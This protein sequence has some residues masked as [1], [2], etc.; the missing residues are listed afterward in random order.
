MSFSLKVS[1]ALFTNYVDKAVPYASDAAG[2]WLMGS[3][4]DSRK[5]LITGAVSSVIG[6][7]VYGKGI[8]ALSNLNGFET[9]IIVSSSEPI[10][11]VSVGSSSAGPYAG[12]WHDGLTHSMLYGTSAT[13]AASFVYLGGSALSTVDNFPASPAISFKAGTGSGPSGVRKLYVNDG[14]GMVTNTT[15]GAG[16]STVTNTFRIGT[17]GL[18]AGPYNCAA[19]MFFRKELSASQIGEIYDYLK[20]KLG[21]RGVNVL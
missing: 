1:D 7:P 16:G 19:T 13:K 2:L 21:K 8:V 6:T 17:G 20:F 10:T 14:S 3:E 5:N 11:I 9:G 15:T 12:M 18:A 4:A